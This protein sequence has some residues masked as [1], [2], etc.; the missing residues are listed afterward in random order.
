M[1]E[2]DGDAFVKMTQP[3][4]VEWLPQVIIGA[5]YEKMSI[6]SVIWSTFSRIEGSTCDGG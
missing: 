5:W 2:E 4:P 6:F 3:V 1:A